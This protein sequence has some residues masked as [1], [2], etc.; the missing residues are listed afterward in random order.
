VFLNIDLGELPGEPEELY[1]CAHV[2]NIACG[3]HAGDAASMSRAVALCREHGTCVGAHPSFPDREGFGRRAL[4][5]PAAALRAAAASQC[6]ALAETARAAG[7]RVE[8]VKAHG[9]LYHA[10]REDGDLA[11]ALLAAVRESLGATVTVIGPPAGAL[12]AAAA[13]AGVS[14]AREGFADRATRPDGTLV[15]RSDPGALLLDPRAAADRARELVRDGHFDTVCVHG[16]TPGAAAI[17]RAVRAVL[18][19]WSAARGMREA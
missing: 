9:A 19:A 2:A 13:R 16:D 3:G 7:T 12:A 15:P 18:D 11:E 6:A 14:Y 1:A 8:F 10:A 17:A 4:A 5:I